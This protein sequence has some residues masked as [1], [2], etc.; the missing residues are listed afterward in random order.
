MARDRMSCGL[1]LLGAGARASTTGSVS[2]ALRLRGDDGFFEVAIIIFMLA[3][4]R[5]RSTTRRRSLASVLLRPQR[6]QRVLRVG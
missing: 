5:T 3:A 2:T 6:H 4:H 1:L